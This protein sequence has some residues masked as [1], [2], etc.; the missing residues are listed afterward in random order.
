L[1]APRRRWTDDPGPW[2]LDLARRELRTHGVA[3]RLGGRAFDIIEA[4]AQSAGE[5]VTKDEIIRRVWRG[6]IVEESTLQVHISAIRKALGPDRGRLKTVFGRGYRLLGAWTIRREEI[7]PAPVPLR[8]VPQ[9]VTA[10]STNLPSASC[11][12]IGR[13]GAVRHLQDRLSAYRIVTL[14]G[15]GG[16]GKSALGLE[17]ARNLLA[18]FN[19]DI[20]LVEFASLSDPDLV[21]SAVA[22]VLGLE[23]GGGGISA[24]TVARAIGPT[25]LLLVLDNCEHVIDAAAKLV[26]TMVR[27]CPRTTVL[28]TS[29]EG[30]RI[31]GECVYRVPPLEVPPEHWEEPHEVLRRSAVELLITRMRALEPEFSS[32]GDGLAA[33][34]AICRHLDGIPL[35]IEFAATRAATLGLEQVASLL[36]DRFTLLTGGRRT[37]LPR[38]RTLRAM[39]DWSY[40]L[41]PEAERR[42]LRRLAVFPAGF[43]LEAAA[44][45]AGD[46]TPPGVAESIANLVAK[47]LVTRDGSVTAGRWRLLDTIRA[48]GLG[49][50][51]ES[52]EAEQVARRCAEFFRDLFVRAALGSSRELATAD[53]AQYAREIDNVRAAIDWSFSPSGDAGIGVALT[54]A[55]APIWLNLS[56]AA[57]LRDRAEHALERVDANLSTRTH[58]EL[59]IALGT[60]L[61]ITLG[62]IER[63]RSVLT[64]ALEIAEC[65][66]DLDAQVRGFWALWAL[67]LN[68][69]ECG[70]AQSVAERFSRVASRTG[71]PGVI[72]VADRVMGYTLQYLGNH[73]AAQRCFERV[74]QIYVAPQRQRDK[75]W[76]LYDQRAVTRAML[77]RSLWLQGLVDQAKSVAQASLTDAET[78]NDKLTI[79]FVLALAV[80]PV[81]LTTGDLVTAERSLYMLIET[82][83]RQ[84]FVRYVNLGRCLE[85]ALL[86]ER[87]EFEAGTALMVT[88][89][90]A[91]ANSGW[92]GRFTEYLGILARGIAGLGQICKALAT[93][94]QALARADRGAERWYVAELLR[95][96]GELLLQEA[97]AQSVSAGEN[98]LKEALDAAPEQGA[99]FWELRA[100]ISLAQLRVKQ[101]RQDDAQQVL[102]PVYDRFTEGSETVDLRAARA[103]LESCGCSLSPDRAS[104]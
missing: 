79:C 25:K 97:T 52:G 23:L 29:R 74:L 90:E 45:V 65:L 59:Q 72:L 87:R 57:E 75:V 84:S 47:S 104:T 62:S 54:A 30:L 78:A 101:N 67:Y 73:R 11:E 9:I 15:P 13:S 35:A 77:A 64:T 92:L 89:L 27:V 60:C 71:D 86:I 8:I 85:A 21:P 50:L 24:E 17:V 34:A 37:A 40:D 96:K 38:H 26:E 39:L 66:D 32:D 48:Y 36:D 51:A 19:G 88:A 69:G 10:N 44:A 103:V 61:T 70:A 16:I 68:T 12:L 4:L 102:A 49:R 2:E 80:F 95:I 56:L 42:L 3:V 83:T 20:W 99:L 100:A 94:D 46:S 31:E 28:A 7:S 33:I 81:A 63:T 98:C 5:L 14:T 76:F 91:R 1:P 82:A 93:V 53:L 43:T 22:G 18:T 58:M 55:Y 6:A 41:L